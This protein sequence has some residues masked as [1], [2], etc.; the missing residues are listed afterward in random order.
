MGL[1]AEEGVEVGVVDVVEEEEVEG[2]VEGLRVLEEDVV[3]V[4]LAEE[5][6]E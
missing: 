4:D 5:V 6:E 2:V 1:D 3:V